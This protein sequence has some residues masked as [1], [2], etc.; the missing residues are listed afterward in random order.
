MTHPFKQSRGRPPKDPS[1]AKCA[2]CGVL[3]RNHGAV[4]GRPWTKADLTRRAAQGEFD[5]EPVWLDRERNYFVVGTRDWQWRPEDP[6]SGEIDILKQGPDADLLDW[7]EETTNRA[8]NGGGYVDVGPGWL[9]AHV[10]WRTPN[11]DY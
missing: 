7:A 10:I 5:Y 3:R 2:E 9:V 1:Q 6:D 11:D 8:A 4:G